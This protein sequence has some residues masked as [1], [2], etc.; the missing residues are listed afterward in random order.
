MSEKIRATTLAT[1]GETAFKS[2]S[3]A[4]ARAY[5]NSALGLVPDLPQAMHGMGL[6]EAQSGNIAKAIEFLEPVQAKRPRDAAVTSNLGN[7][8]KLS[9]QLTRAVETYENALRL[10]PKDPNTHNNLGA[11]LIDLGRR[12]EAIGPLQAAIKLA[13][14]HVE[15]HFNLGRAYRKLEKHEKAIA[16]YQLCVLLK[17]DFPQAYYELGLSMFAIEDNRG[18]LVAFDKAVKLRPGYG[19]ACNGRGTTLLS[20]GRIEEAQ[21]SLEEAVTLIP[22][23][24]EAHNNLGLVFQKKKDFAKA[25]RHH[26]EAVR[27]HP[28]YPEAHNNCG[29]AL[30][31]L[32]RYG[33]AYACFEVALRLRESFPGALSNFAG[34]LK[35]M[36]RYEESLAVYERAISL[37]PLDAYIYNCGLVHLHMQS[38]P[39]GWAMYERRWSTEQFKGHDLIVSGNIVDPLQSPTPRWSPEIPASRL[40]IWGEQ[41]LGD[42]LLYGSLLGLIAPRFES[43][44]VLTDA[45]L[46]N[47]FSRANPAITFQAKR[48]VPP[49]DRYD[50]HLP[51][52][53]LGQY[54]VRS[55]E[56][57]S[58]RSIPYV[59]PD[60]NRVEEMLRWRASLGKRRLVGISWRSSSPKVGR[61]KS[62]SLETLLPVLR[63]PDTAFVN[64][65]Y[66]SASEEIET[67]R[68]RHQVELHQAPG[69][70]TFADIEGVAAL[71]Q[72]CDFV[73]SSSNTN[74]HLAG[75]MGKPVWLLAP[76]GSGLL[77]Y[78]SPRRGGKSLWYPSIEL[79]EQDDQLS[80]EDAIGEMARR[81]RES[82]VAHESRH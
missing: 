79:F 30:Q 73:V 45:R 38:Y 58:R 57:L 33:E 26:Q 35:D 14:R 55:P 78:W 16:E 11:A 4:Q 68:T 48:E 65:Q 3:L 31:E 17:S 66:G 67:L 63:D 44:T 40:L 5:F 43:V 60:P 2:G 18:A 34:L 81:L 80:W 75:A 46:V 56:D 29:V 24:A 15:A 37:S 53:S 32:Q 28:D 59:M 62:M 10:N 39:Q 50:A 8:Y 22:S 23:Y 36:Q 1:L 21:A 13:P 51:V 54:T 41:G 72:I 7:L 69:L 47:L 74:V 61:A 6:I 71:I 19:E 25:L 52:A 70:D 82:H 9:G 12:D 42:E 49:P 77:W 64:L 76:Y 27:L 20:L